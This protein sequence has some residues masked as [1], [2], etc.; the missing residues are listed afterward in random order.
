MLEKKSSR[1][2]ILMGVVALVLLV[3][4]LLP[5]ISCG[6]PEPTT[7]TPTTTTPT[8]TPFTPIT[9]VFACHES[10]TGIMYDLFWKPWM[11]EVE[12]RTGGR[13]KI[14]GHYNGELAAPPDAWD[15]VINGT[16]DVSYVHLQNHPGKFPMC[17]IVAFTSYGLVNDK[18]G[19]TMLELYN[20]Y[21][22]MQQELS[23]VH[24]L[25]LGS[26]YWTSYAGTKPVHTLEDFQGLK[27][28]GVGKWQNRRAEVLGMVPVS[29]GPFDIL[30]S[31][32]TGVIDGGANGTMLIA[33]DFGYMDYLDYWTHYRMEC[34]PLII[35]VNLDVWDSLPADIQQILDDMVSWTTALWDSMWVETEHTLYPEVI[36]Q[37]EEFYTPSDEELARWD[38]LDKP[39]WDEYAEELES[40]GLPGRALVDD[41]IALEAKYSYP[42]SDWTP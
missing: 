33:L 2:R 34:I 13:V 16:V 24:L 5:A 19:T 42:L 18:L 35:G 15:V 29:M 39:V 31:L 22:E 32:Q 17:D 27:A 41:Y 3:S 28:L 4:L 40:Q 14:E 26:T 30:P 25:L 6:E 20:K 9:L 37:L 10:S 36:A 38:A 7:T 21:P 11:E 23:E 1:F 12:N 8:T